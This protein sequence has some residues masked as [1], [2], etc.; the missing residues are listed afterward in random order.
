MIAE[1]KENID[2]DEDAITQWTKEHSYDII[3]KNLNMI[4]S[5]F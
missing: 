4:L 3:S 2:R 5:V 1:K